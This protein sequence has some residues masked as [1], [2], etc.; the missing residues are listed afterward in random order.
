MEF[1]DPVGA[2]QKA[3]IPLLG[4]EWRDETIADDDVSGVIFQDCV[5]ED[6]R[7]ER[8]AFEQTMFLQCRLIDC[9][10]ADAKLVNTRL[11][12]C[13]GAGF[14]ATGG[15]LQDIALSECRFEA[16][17]FRQ[18]ALRLVLA[19]S[20][21]ERLA[22]SGAGSQQD[23][24]TISGCEFGHVE[25]ENAVWHGVSAVDV[26]LRGWTMPN[27]EFNRCCFIRASADEADLSSVRF[28][29]C[30]LYQSSFRGTRLRRGEGS[31]FA[32]CDLEEA[33]LVEASLAGALFAKCRAPKARFDRA[34]IEQAIFAGAA[35]AGASFAGALATQSVWTD[36]DLTGANLDRASA[37]RGVFRNAELKD[38]SVVGANL[39]EA[40]LHGVSA[41]LDGADTNGARGTIDWRAD[42]EAALRAEGDAGQSA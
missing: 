29:A 42:R 39:A 35:L 24:L 15:E 4:R 19:E 40:D 25:A 5:F 41:P 16:L 23:T 37:F 13:E 8:V 22:F 14:H 2:H 18:R 28:N 9:A 36:A 34:Q 21:V 11:V 33:D 7:F 38:A 20:R 1:K 30:N 12:G 17:D 3:G 6:V 10:F 31:I 26:D 32:E 27:A